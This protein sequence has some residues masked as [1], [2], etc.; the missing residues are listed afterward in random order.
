MGWR[1]R[2]RLRLGKGLW[3]NVSKSRISASIGRPGVTLNVGADG[4]QTTVSLPGT[5]V[6]YRFKRRRFSRSVVPYIVPA[7]GLI[8]IVFWLLHH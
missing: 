5:G 1:F 3:I 8:G 6:S 7:I 4:V 2:W